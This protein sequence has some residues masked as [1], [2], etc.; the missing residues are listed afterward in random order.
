MSLNKWHCAAL[1]QLLT[2]RFRPTFLAL[3]IDEENELIQAVLSCDKFNY[4]TVNERTISVFNEIFKEMP[5]L[6]EENLIVLQC[7]S[8]LEME[9]VLDDMFTKELQ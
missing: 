7:F 5:S 6:I 1:E 4:Q 9:R 2:I 8:S 3:T